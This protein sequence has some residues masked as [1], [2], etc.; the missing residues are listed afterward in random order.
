[1][2]SN[3]AQRMYIWPSVPLQKDRKRETL[4]TVKGESRAIGKIPLPGRPREASVPISREEK[5]PPAFPT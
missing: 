2:A 4:G 1:M 3:S 5:R